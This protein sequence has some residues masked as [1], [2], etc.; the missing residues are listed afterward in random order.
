M[1]APELLPDAPEE[2]PDVLPL[3]IPDVPPS[4][5]PEPLAPPEETVVPEEVPEVLPEL[6]GELLFEL[7]PSPNAKAKGKSR[8]SAVRRVE[9]DRMGA[10]DVI[11]R[12]EKESVEKGYLALWS[13]WAPRIGRTPT[14]GRR[15]G[16]RSLLVSQR[17]FEQPA[18]RGQSRR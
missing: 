1:A 9:V 5:A 10:S 15:V 12:Q 7:Q 6:L 2:A 16:L 17:S 18:Y 14:F 3:E 8:Q 13:G 11:A 4:E